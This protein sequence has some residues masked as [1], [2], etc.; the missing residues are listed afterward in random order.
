MKKN[1]MKGPRGRGKGK[2]FALLGRAVLFVGQ[3]A[4]GLWVV[5]MLCTH[6]QDLWKSMSPAPLGQQLVGEAQAIRTQWAQ[7]D[8]RDLPVVRPWVGQATQ[9]WNQ[10]LQ[11]LQI[12]SST[13]VNPVMG[14]SPSVLTSA[15]Q[16]VQQV[17]SP[18]VTPIQQAAQPAWQQVRTQ[19][20]ALAPASSSTPTHG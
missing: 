15:A 10:A 8:I 7:S 2:M 18:Y 13:P 6:G 1:H 17:A 20:Q 9:V 11:H 12:G 5:M 14:Q 19:V 4:L 3:C 16:Q